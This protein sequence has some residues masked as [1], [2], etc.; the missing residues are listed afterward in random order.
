MQDVHILML[1]QIELLINNISLMNEYKNLGFKIIWD[2]KKNKL[3]I[4]YCKRKYEVSLIKQE[5][6]IYWH[7]KPYNN[8][9]FNSALENGINIVFFCH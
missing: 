8:S 4:T 7:L 9:V 6:K 1:K 3:I 2:K 5:D